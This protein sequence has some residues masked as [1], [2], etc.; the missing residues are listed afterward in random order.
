MGFEP[1]L[2]REFRLKRNDIT[3]NRHTQLYK[4]FIF[5]RCIKINHIL[6]NNK[7]SK[8]DG[9]KSSSEQKCFFII[10]FIFLKFAL[11]LVKRHKTFLVLVSNPFFLDWFYIFCIWFWVLVKCK[12]WFIF[13][14]WFWF[15]YILFLYWLPPIFFYF[16]I[17]LLLSH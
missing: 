10:V 8:N 13:C 5:F 16:G 12:K 3:T 9:K 6:K 17:P 1:M 2:P 11:F 14:I 7:N 4:H 15:L